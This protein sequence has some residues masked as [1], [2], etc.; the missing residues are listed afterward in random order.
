M[1]FTSPRAMLGSETSHMKKEPQE[2]KEPLEE[3][4]ENV[5]SPFL[6]SLTFSLVLS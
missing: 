4:G 6:D 1:N 2:E 5:S 3:K